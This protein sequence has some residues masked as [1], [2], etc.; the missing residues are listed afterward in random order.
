MLLKTGCVH[1]DKTIEQIRGLVNGWPASSS[2]NGVLLAVSGGI[3]SMCMAELFAGL[4]EPLPFAVAHCNFHLRGEESDGDE[5]LVRSWAEEHGIRLHVHDFD[6]AAYAR[7]SGISIEMAARDLRYSWF[8]ELCRE[9]GYFA[10]AVAHNANDNAE[11]LMLNLLRGSGMN[12][13]SGMSLV[14]KL[15]TGQPD[16]PY[17][18]RPLLPFTRK[19]IEGYALANKVSYRDDSTNASSEYKR[20]RIRNV[21]FPVF[22]T[23]N[24]SFIRTLNR[25]MNNFAEA[26]EIVSDYCRAIVPSLVSS[27]SD[28]SVSV[29][30]QALMAQKHWC[31]LLYFI[32]EPYG[33]N[34]ATLASLEDLLASSR[35]VSGKSFTSP[36][37]RLNMERNHMV[38]CPFSTEAEASSLEAR[39]TSIMPVRAA[40][41]YH[42]NGRVFKV[43]V[44]PW[45]DGMPLK[46]PENVLI[47]DADKLRFPFVLRAWRPGDWL[48]PLGMRGKKKVS[49]LFT[50][51]KFTSL[52]KKSAVMIVDT[53]TA[54]F[55][56]VQHLAAVACLRVDNIYKVTDST[57]SVIRISEC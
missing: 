41:T 51:L 34:S 42:F 37:H 14:S 16:A 49:D 12:G 9:Y 18:L 6:T 20:N 38:I 50:D 27:G 5:A 39:N 1:F 10:V 47:M 35:T 55:A 11:T 2:C 40:G 4:D 32:L 19:Q 46:Q 8:E 31:Y 44:L 57:E 53:M 17:L 30:L 23:I 43:E 48:V 29:D 52:Q 54:G 26:G 36:S 28:G 13:L 15:P 21:A 22:E 25:G 3:D 7:E 24:P 33:F 56:D 45:T